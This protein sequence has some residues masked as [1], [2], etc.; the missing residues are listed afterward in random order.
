MQIPIPKQ[1]PIFNDRNFNPAL[2][3]D[4]NLVFAV[5]SVYGYLIE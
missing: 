4:W 3:Q 5:L 1:I 2:G